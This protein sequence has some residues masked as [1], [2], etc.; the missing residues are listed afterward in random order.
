MLP[1]S[2]ASREPKHGREPI[3]D[4]TLEKHNFARFERPQQEHG[5]SEHENGEI[6]GDMAVAL[7]DKSRVVTEQYALLERISKTHPDA[8]AGEEWR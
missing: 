2:G 3:A 6:R 5:T 7:E 4:Q 1:T 8:L